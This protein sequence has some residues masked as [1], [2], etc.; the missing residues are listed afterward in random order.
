MGHAAV[1]EGARGLEAVQ[2]EIDGMA[3]AR[4]FR[5]GTREEEGGAYEEASGS[6]L[7]GCDFGRRREDGFRIYGTERG[8]WKR[9]DRVMMEI[10]ARKGVKR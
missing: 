1:L 5:Q 2:F 6:C 4:Q 3:V 9:G 7:G 8:A 10:A